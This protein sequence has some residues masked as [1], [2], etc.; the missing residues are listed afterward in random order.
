MA[1]A[2]EIKGLDCGADVLSGVRLVLRTRLAEM[3]ALG[4]RATDWSNIEG[5]H[6]MRVASRRLRSAMK[7]FE[8]FL[9]GKSGLRGLSAEVR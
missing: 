7:D 5:V 9:R 6:D 1:K 4:N 2:N 3:C 8:L